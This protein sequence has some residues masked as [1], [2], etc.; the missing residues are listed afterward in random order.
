M[1]NVACNSFPER[2]FDISRSRGN[3]L[4]V[5][6]FTPGRLNATEFVFF[7]YDSTF[8]AHMYRVSVESM[9]NASPHLTDRYR[10]I[11]PLARKVELPDVMFAHGFESHA[12]LVVLP[13]QEGMPAYL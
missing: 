3:W 2:Q 11:G 8:P 1:T 9:S 13:V 12:K 10:D 7:N 5:P 6:Y 4:T